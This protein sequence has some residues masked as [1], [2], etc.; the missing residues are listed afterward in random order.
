M[1]MRPPG[2]R[3][4]L[5][6]HGESRLK[7]ALVAVVIGCGGSESGD[8]SACKEWDSV[9]QDA[10]EDGY[11]VGDALSVCVDDGVPRGFTDRSPNDGGADCDDADPQRNIQQYFYSDTDGDGFGA[12]GAPKESACLDAVFDGLAPNRDDCDDSDPLRHRIMYVDADDDGYGVEGQSTCEH[13]EAEGYATDYGDC[14]DAAPNVFPGSAQEIPLDGVDSDCDGIDATIQY[15][16]D[17]QR[18]PTAASARTLNCDESVDLLFE[19]LMV[20]SEVC[21]PW[22]SVMV[23]NL[24][25][26]PAVTWTLARGDVP[27][28]YEQAQELAPGAVSDAV[29]IEGSGPEVELR[30]VVAGDVEDCNPSNN[31]VRFPAPW[32][33]CM[34]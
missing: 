2:R 26:V 7:L 25:S 4:R 9:Y 23:A 12:G 6:A 24:G 28:E 1:R 31:V 34:P 14:D 20:C 11:G 19:E 29:V 22:F 33:A 13:S 15:C 3:R 32:E 21:D 27:G 16:D 5:D 8:E 30:I 18:V 17:V 10:D